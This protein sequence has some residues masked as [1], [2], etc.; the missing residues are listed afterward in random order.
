MSVVR[1]ALTQTVNAYK[2][3]PAKVADL[4]RL[5]GRLDDIRAANVEH[6]VAL[7]KAAARAGAKIAC[8]GELCTAPYFALGKDPMWLALAEDAERGPSVKAF[9]KAATLSASGK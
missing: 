8:L 5:K 6:N 1:A 9:A 4:G 7:I 2:G 3:M